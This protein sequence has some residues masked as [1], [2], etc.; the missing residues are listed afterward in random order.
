[1][2]LISLSTVTDMILRNRHHVVT[3]MH[4]GARVFKGDYH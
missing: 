3:D 2:S 4:D 1:M